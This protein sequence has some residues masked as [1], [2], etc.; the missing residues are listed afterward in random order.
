MHLL[1]PHASALSPACA[2]TLSHLALP[3]LSRLLSRLQAA[4]PDTADE[5][6]LS[7]PHERALGRCLGLQGEDGALPWAARAAQADGLQV[8]AQAE[9]SP[10][11]AW[12]LMSP[13]FWQ[14]G[15]EHVTLSDPE[16]LQLDEDGSRA[17][18]E[19][20]RGLFESEGFGIHWGAPL[21]WYLSHDSL[22]GLPCASIDRVIGRNVDLW[23]QT[24]TQRFPQ[25]RLIR[26]L[27][28]EV[29]MLLYTHPLT[30][31]REA[32]G[33]QPVNS[34]WLSGCGRLQAPPTDGSTTPVVDTRLR[35][36]LL[37]EDWAA[38]AEAWL[39]LDSGPVSELLARASQGEAVT[40]TLCGERSAQRYTAQPRSLWQ[41]LS[42]PW[43][44]TDT[45]RVLEA[46]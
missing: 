35:S 32:H 27:Q 42:Q 41:R 13:V 5:Y 20:V 1:I 24:D 29:Q 12:G 40:L 38:W 2:H 14:V 44:S 4:P 46:L 3:Q 11:P 26:R 28:N 19:A 43:Q 34:F 9:G 39:A 15:R 21:R 36:P 6:T 25:A 18:F 30:D 8:Q 22:D 37:A 10:P 31:Q 45:A 33:L 16:Q 23:L 7:P 17:A